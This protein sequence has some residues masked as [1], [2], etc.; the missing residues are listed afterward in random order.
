VTMRNIRVPGRFVVVSDGDVGP[1]DIRIIGG[2]VGPSV[3]ANVV[4]GSNG[5]ETPA[6]PRNVLIDGVTFH[7]F[8]LAPGSDAHVECLQVWAAD[9]LTI[10]NSRFRNCWVFDIFV[11]K[12]DGFPAATP[13]N[14]L[15]E[16]DFLDCCG[17]GDNYSLRLS[18][19]Y[20][21]TWKNVTI[22]NN[23]SNQ[24]F[25]IGPGTTYD[26]VAVLANIA[27]LVD[28]TPSGVKF[29]YNVWYAGRAVGAGDRVAPA[30]YRDP[31]RLDFHL[32]PGAAA[33][34][35]GDP[36]SYPRTDI[37]GQRRPLGSGPDAGADERR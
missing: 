28:G 1:R 23:S 14:I 22:R 26:R 18:D 11:S 36:S 3:D 21:G 19:S 27:P 4:I 20:G 16:N 15:I 6:S 25:S 34:G 12:G 24:K 7:D 31:A 8:T 13:S 10:R 35:H 32:R 37:D 30:G 17:G 2:D 29:A 33:I 9:G 5:Y